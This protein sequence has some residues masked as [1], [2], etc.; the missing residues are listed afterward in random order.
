MRVE[1]GAV[2]DHGSLLLTT[3]PAQLVR[4]YPFASITWSRFNGSATLP[5]DTL[6]LRADLMPTPVGSPVIA[7]NLNAPPGEVKAPAEPGKSETRK[8]DSFG[9]SL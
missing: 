6:S 8:P 1:C 3:R 7:V 4:S 5:R 9:N 2:G